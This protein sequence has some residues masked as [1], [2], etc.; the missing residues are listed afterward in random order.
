M[1][2]RFVVVK[3]GGYDPVAV[4]QYM[5]KL[6]MELR[7][8]R[9]KGAT[10]NHAI[11]SAQQA[12]DNIVLNAKNQ[13]RLIKESTAKQLEDISTSINSQRQLLND[14]V[15]EYN[16]IIAKYLKVMDSQDF[17]LVS[18]KID[19]LEAFLHSFSEEVHEDLEIEKKSGG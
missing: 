2:D 10:I 3:K 5:D 8:H 14:F 6:E 12:A 11:V 7:S 19:A 1:P 9:E 15:R 16:N 17:K 18:G 4:D 13:G